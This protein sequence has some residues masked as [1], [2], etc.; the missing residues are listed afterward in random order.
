MKPEVSIPSTTNPLTTQEPIIN[1][2][3][4]SQG[5]DPATEEP[6]NDLVRQEGTLEKESAEVL[7]AIIEETAGE[8]VIASQVVRDRMASRLLVIKIFLCKKSFSL[9]FC[10]LRRKGE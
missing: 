2:D 10:H 6:K 1:G 3:A 8:S 5:T 4:K 7:R 9:C